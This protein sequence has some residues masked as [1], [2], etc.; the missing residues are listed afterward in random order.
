M[1]KRKMLASSIFLFLILISLNT[2]A[3]GAD[4]K[5][6]GKID[7]FVQYYDPGS[8]SY[9]TKDKDIVRLQLKSVCIDKNKCR[10][11]HKKWIRE[12]KGEMNPAYEKWAYSLSSVEIQCR[13]K[14]IRFLSVKNIDENGKT[15]DGVE[16]PTEWMDIKNPWNQPDPTEDLC[17]IICK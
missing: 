3:A 2:G 10:E 7:P 13:D 4:W 5:I 8:L 15:I 17:K 12:S 9:P 14:K 6:Y 11:L 1:V 16:K